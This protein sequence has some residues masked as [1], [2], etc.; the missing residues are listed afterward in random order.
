[1][2]TFY[3]PLHHK[4]TATT[5][6]DGGVL[7]SPYEKPSRVETILARLQLRE[8][9]PVLP[10][11]MFDMAP[12]LR[13]H[14][15]EYID[16]LQHC[17]KEWKAAGKPGEA[18]PAIW[19]ARG[20][21]Q[22]L[23]EDIDGRLGYFAFSADTSITQGT[24][25]AAKS[26]VDV[27]LSAWQTVQGGERAAFALCRPPGHHAS[28][29]QMGGYCFIN[30]AAVVAQSFID[31]GASRVAILDVDFHHGNGTQSIFY[32]RSDVFT[33]SL[34]GDPDQVFPH[35]LGFEDETGTGEGRGFNLNLCYP[36]GTDY[37]VWKQGLIR[38][39]D[40]L[41]SFKPDALVL[42][43]GVDTYE[44]DPISSFR[45]TSDDYLDLGACIAALGLPAVITME[46]GYAVDAIGVNVV[47]VLEGFQT[48]LE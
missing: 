20:M 23:P 26:S 7:V 37:K 18:I 22:R 27:A 40:Q 8:P 33:V 11:E 35:F 47:N 42:A 4:R 21:R 48:Q 13:V 30:N 2:K 14:D 10:P 43:L 34:H 29:D 31:N 38:A 25:E 24:W 36:P 44:H 16:F 5:E 41:T 3:S 45:F 1:M 12:V 6:L 39:C 17:W 19:P 32:H 28:T 46:G 9:G 15:P